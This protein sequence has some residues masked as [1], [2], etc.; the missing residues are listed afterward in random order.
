MAIQSPVKEAEYALDKKN[1]LKLYDCLLPFV[2]TNKMDIETDM[3]WKIM[4]LS[5]ENE[6]VKEREY[7]YKKELK[8]LKFWE[9]LLEQG[10]DTRDILKELN[11]LKAKH[12]KLLK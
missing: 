4:K 10:I 8:Q 2:K 11:E 12:H 6:A 1:P 3:E 7:W 5:R 9:E